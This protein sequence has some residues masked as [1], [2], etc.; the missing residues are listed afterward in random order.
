MRVASSF[1]ILAGLVTGGLSTASAQTPTKSNV[2]EVFKTYCSGCHNG[3]MRSPSGG[4]LDQFDTTQIAEKPDVWARAYRQLQAGTMPPVGS[5]RPDRATYDSVLTAIEQAWGSNAKAPAT[6]TSLE[7]AERLAALLWNS[8]PDATLFQVAQVDRLREPGALERQIHRMLVDDRAQAFVSRFFF[9]WLGLDKLNNADP[10]KKLY[11][12]FD[13]SLRDAFAKETEL[14]LLSQLRD[15]RDPV[16]LWSA[17]Y[18]FLNDQL[19]RHYDIPDVKG[20]QFRRVTLPSPERAG[21]LGQASVLT[22]ISRHQQGSPVAHT[23]P[24]GR[25]VWVRNHFLGAPPPMPFPGAQPVKPELPTTPQ[26]RTLPAEPCRHCHQ[27]L[28]P[29]GYALENFDP[30]GRWRTNDQLGPVDASGAFVDGTS[31]N[32][33]IELRKVL[34]QRPEAFRTTI[35]ENLL[36]Y[37]SGKPTNSG[38]RSPDTLVRA[39]QILRGMQ[40]PRWSAV[41]A[42][43]VREKPAQ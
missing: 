25:S 20:S 43:I 30:I 15:D 34:L 10:D 28:F 39:R 7:I 32:G 35:T 12:D 11:P 1:L 36:V 5:A 18:T 40:N 33:I 31:T 9:P 13:V 4:L 14:F 21:L 3:S 6:A 8:S 2:A 37:A 19:A 38:Q 17:N 42:G 29:L 41:I 16:E 26:T 22:V 27:N 23:T 24:A